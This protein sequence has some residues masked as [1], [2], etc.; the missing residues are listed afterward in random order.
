MSNTDTQ[1]MV[2]NLSQLSR[3]FT[4]VS[5]YLRCPNKNPVDFIE[6]LHQAFE[7]RKLKSR[8]PKTIIKQLKATWAGCMRNDVN[9][10]DAPVVIPHTFLNAIHQQPDLWNAPLVI[11]H[12]PVIKP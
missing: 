5:A 4:V 1:I 7:A 11:G 6:A 2:S 9:L 12:A 10:L 8:R 3:P